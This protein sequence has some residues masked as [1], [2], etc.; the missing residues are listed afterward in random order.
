MLGA[1]A[2]VAAGYL[3]WRYMQQAAAS[4]VAPDVGASVDPAQ[5]WQ[6]QQPA[7]VV[8][9]GNIDPQQA[10][11]IVNTLN[12]AEFGGF[13]DPRDV[14]AVITVES[15]FNP[16]AVGTS[17]EIGLMQVMPAT[18]RQFGYPD[19]TALF[20]PVEGI[21]AGMRVLRWTWDYLA[22]RLGTNPTELQWFGAYNAGVGNIM[23]GYQNHRYYA[24][25]QAARDNLAFS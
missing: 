16:R 17:G 1:V 25:I 9:V 7:Q 8:P 15:R 6:P 3:L 24:A 5:A 10:L 19:A 12:A 2:L 11:D 13:F 22:Q 18:A 14:M 21:R 20:D 23:R 4:T